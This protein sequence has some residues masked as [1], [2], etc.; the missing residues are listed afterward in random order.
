MPTLYKQLHAGSTII[1]SILQWEIQGTEGP[2]D[3]PKMAK[4]VRDGAELDPDGL[5]QNLDS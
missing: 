1:I 5:F 2:G 4:P 3:I